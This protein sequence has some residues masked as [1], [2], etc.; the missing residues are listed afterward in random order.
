MK[1]MHFKG[2][3]SYAGIANMLELSGY[4]TE[5]YIIASKIKLPYMFDY[6]DGTYLAGTRLQNQKWFNLF[7]N[8]IGFRL[9][10]VKISSTDLV[11]FLQEDRPTMIGIISNKSK[12]AVIYYKHDEHN[13]YFINNKFEYEQCPELIKISATNLISSVPKVL[14]IGYLK[15][16]E[17]ENVDI[18]SRLIS[19]AKTLEKMN[20]D[21]LSYC[22]TVHNKED[23]LD[24]REDL[25]RALFLEA[26]IMYQLE[27]NQYLYENLLK[28]QHSLIHALSREND[29]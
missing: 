7:L 20:G 2:G 9:V 4:D 13:L 23:I 14:T 25:F 22:S 27:D 6:V 24:C 10:E 3:C 1:Y 29:I 12:H 11:N 18:I 28:L 21:L 17:V 5:D 19:S 16:C 26:P 8:Q 15:K